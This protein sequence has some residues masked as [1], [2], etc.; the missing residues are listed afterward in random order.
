LNFEVI[1]RPIF[2]QLK[3]KPYAIKKLKSSLAK[4]PD[5]NYFK[6]NDI[7]HDYKYAPLTNSACE[8]SFSRLNNMLT[9][10][11]LGMTPPNIQKYL[12]VNFNQFL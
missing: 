7:L 5:I 3:D 12:F 6:S 9:D 8:R 1:F 2:S 10:L 4:N 11:R